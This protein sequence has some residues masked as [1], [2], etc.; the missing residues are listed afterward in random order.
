[1]IAVNW[2]IVAAIVG[3]T[4]I[5]MDLARALVDS[6]EGP[7]WPRETGTSDGPSGEVEWVRSVLDELEGKRR[8]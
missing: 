8:S 7:S 3:W 1:M 6:L 2:W 5:F 4:L